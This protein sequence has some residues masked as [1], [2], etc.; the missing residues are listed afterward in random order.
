MIIIKQKTLKTFQRNYCDIRD[1]KTHN[2]TC[3]V[4]LKREYIL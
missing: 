2:H 1:T 4:M 3:T